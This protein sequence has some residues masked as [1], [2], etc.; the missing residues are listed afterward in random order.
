MR[1]GRENGQAMLETIILGLLLIVPIIWLLGLL[2]EMH[3]AALATTAAAREAA[4]DAARASDGSSARASIDRAVRTALED[5]GLEPG[6]ARVDASTPTGYQ[7]GAEVTVQVSYP[8]RA[9]SVPLL[10]SLTEPVIWIRAR[11][12][13]VIEPFRSRE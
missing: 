11:T 6:R 9:L 4:F 12:S 1:S 8:V 7:R 5:Q 3:R 10:G 13:M 2:G